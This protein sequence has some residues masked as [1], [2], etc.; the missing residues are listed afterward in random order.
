MNIFGLILLISYTDHS[1]S[2]EV[3]CQL[4]GISRSCCTVQTVLL[5]IRSITHPLYCTS[6]LLQHPTYDSCLFLYYLRVRI[7]SENFWAAK[8]G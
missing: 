1:S 6:D 7:G 4:L 3:S 2:F 5:P 8:M